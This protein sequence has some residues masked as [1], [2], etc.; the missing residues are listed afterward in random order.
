MDDDF[1]AAGGDS[2]LTIQLLSA[3]QRE[4]VDLTPATFYATPTFGG[5]IASLHRGRVKATVETTA[6]RCHPK[7]LALRGRIVPDGVA[8]Y[9]CALR[10]WFKRSSADLFAVSLMCE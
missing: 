4:G 8:G 6:Q 1:Y 9:L 7:V 10:G 2:I 5:L 3:L